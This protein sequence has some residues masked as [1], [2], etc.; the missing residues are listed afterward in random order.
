[1]Q[2]I[3]KV[4]LTDSCATLPVVWVMLGCRSGINTLRGDYQKTVF[5]CYGKTG[6]L[7]LDE[8]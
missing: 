6:F 1:M 2:D 8:T 5:G 3:T 4:T 7:S